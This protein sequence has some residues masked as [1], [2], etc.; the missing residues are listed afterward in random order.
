[1][2][3][4]QG[5]GDGLIGSD[6]QA[7]ASCSITD[8]SGVGAW[9]VTVDGQP[10]DQ[11]GDYYSIIGPLAVGGHTFVVNASDADTSSSAA[12]CSGAFAVVAAED[13]GVSYGGWPGALDF[14]TVGLGQPESRAVIIS[15][16]GEQSLSIGGVT[17][18]PGFTV[19]QPV[20]AGLPSGGKTHFTVTLDTS[21]LGSKSGSVSIPNSDSN[22]SFNVTGKVVESPRLSVSST[23]FTGLPV[24]ATP[25]EAGGT[26]DYSV[27]LASRH[28]GVV[29]HSSGSSQHRRSRLRVLSNGC[30][31]KRVEPCHVHRHE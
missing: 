2:A 14:G 18:P 23:P 19:T 17:A 29:W 24:S 11:A 25:P 13:I 16:N 21:T 12:S 5:D 3:E 20:S 28:G 10:V 31:R 26:T 7:I 6:E 15:N 27:T 1:M 30:G 9:S 8:P 4:Y 22:F